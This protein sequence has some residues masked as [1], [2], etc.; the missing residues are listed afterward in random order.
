MAV[1]GWDANPKGMDKAPYFLKGVHEISSAN[2]SEINY[3]SLLKYKYIYHTPMY[4]SNQPSYTN[5]DRCAHTNIHVIQPSDV[6]Q[7]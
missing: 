2:S 7:P 5:K 6:T 4:I 3:S 1:K